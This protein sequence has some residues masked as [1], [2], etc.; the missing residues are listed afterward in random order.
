LE[1]GVI[2]TGATLAISLE[3]RSGVTLPDVDGCGGEDFPVREKKKQLWKKEKRLAVIFRK[4][5]K[6]GGRGRKKQSDV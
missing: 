5:E 1:I 4:A 2:Q 6:T 3:K